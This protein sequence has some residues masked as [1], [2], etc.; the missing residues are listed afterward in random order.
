M[1]G[2][3][4]LG[5]AIIGCGEIGVVDANAARAADNIEVVACYSRT[6]EAAQEVAGDTATAYGSTATGADKQPRD[7]EGSMGMLA[8]LAN[9]KVDAVM[10]CLPHNLHEPYARM[11]AQAGK[12]ILTEKPLA[13]NLQDAY[14]LGEAARSN[15]VML[16]VCL[17][18]RFEPGIGEI[19]DR[20][21]EMGIGGIV[22]KWL[23]DKPDTY[24]NAGLTS[25]RVSQ[26]RRFEYSAGGG[27]W[28]MNGFHEVDLIN[29][30]VGSDALYVTAKKMHNSSPTSRQVEDRAEVEVL[31]QGGIA[32]QF[33]YDAAYE[34]EPESSVTIY[35]PD[36]K[37]PESIVLKPAHHIAEVVTKGKVTS[38]VQYGAPGPAEVYEL[39][40]PPIP[41]RVRVLELF[42]QAVIEG[43]K[44]LLPAR[45]EHAI[46]AQAVIGAGYASANLDGKRV[47][48]DLYKSRAQS[49]ALA[50]EYPASVLDLID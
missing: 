14:K 15:N 17:P 38:S 49:L 18:Q 41:S 2:K 22:V 44:R 21:Q 11:A 47:K 9:D 5:L 23:Q 48:V 27:A 40:A 33:S 1:T 6:L 50:S 28:L 39:G 8:L 4:K 29:T 36:S 46:A 12:H 7:V 25:R 42:A 31:Y 34:G 26:W 35:G 24:W 37:N 20:A 43:K 32:A 10:L 45:F 16:S 30:I 13:H 19:R 3:D